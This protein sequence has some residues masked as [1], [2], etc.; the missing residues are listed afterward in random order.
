MIDDSFARKVDV[1]CTWAAVAAVV[2]ILG[3]M[4]QIIPGNAFGLPAE[5][6]LL[7]LFVLCQAIS[8][9]MKILLWLKRR[10]ERDQEFLQ[11]IRAYERSAAEH[12]GRSM[13][14]RIE[15]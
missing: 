12:L 1:I 5:I 14:E 13:E 4:I 15:E 10:Q 8:L 3:I 9:W 2:C 11:N 7:C 6:L